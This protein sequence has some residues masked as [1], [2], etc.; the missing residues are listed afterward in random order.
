MAGSVAVKPDPKKFHV[1]MCETTF[2]V[3]PNVDNMFLPSSDKWHTLGASSIFESEAE[4]LDDNTEKRGG[5]DSSAA[6]NTTKSVE[7]EMNRVYCQWTVIFY[8]NMQTL[9]TKL[10]IE[11]SGGYKAGTAAFP[12]GKHIHSLREFARVWKR[13]TSVQ[14][15]YQQP[16]KL[17]ASIFTIMRLHRSSRCKVD[18]RF[19]IQ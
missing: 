11:D 18:D 14:S 6:H 5:N 10:S 8:P 13:A 17:T 3:N 1:H 16:I 7:T 9:N 2:A 12:K 4:T 19:V 15:F